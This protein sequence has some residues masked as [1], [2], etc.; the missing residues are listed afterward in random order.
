MRKGFAKYIFLG[1]VI[2]IML[3][4]LASPMSMSET[5]QSFDNQIETE[6][7]VDDFNLVQPHTLSTGE[8][9]LSGWHYRQQHTMLAGAGAG[10]NYA[11]TLHVEYGAGSS[12]GGIFHSNS[13]CQ[14]NFGDIRFTDNN[15]NTQLDYWMEEK[16]DSDDAT[17]WIEIKDSL[18][19][20]IS[21]YVYYGTTGTSSTTSS[22]TN[23]F[24]FFDDFENNNLNRW[25]TAGSDWSTSTS[26]VKYGT[27]AAYGD[28]DP[29]SENR[30]L[31]HDLTVGGY[32]STNIMIHLW[33]QVDAETYESHYGYATD[34]G[35]STAYPLRHDN[36][37]WVYDNGPKLPWESNTAHDDI[38]Y[39]IELV[40]DFTSKYFRLWID[41]NSKGSIDLEDATG[42]DISQFGLWQII[43][44]NVAGEDMW[45]DDVYIRKW[46]SSEPAHSTWLSE[47]NSAP[48]NDVTP[49]CTNLD[50]GDNLYARYR[51]YNFSVSVTDVCGA[52]NINYV[53]LSSMNG[54]TPVWTVK[55]LESDNSFSEI[56][57]TTLIELTGSV[58]TKSGVNL[59]IWFGVRIE[60]AHVD[61][62][63][64]DLKQYALDDDGLSDTDTYSAIDYDYDTDLTT[65]FTLNDGSGTADHGNYNSI[66]SITASGTV[67]YEDSGG[68]NYP[69]TAQVDMFIR[70]S[71]V[72][73][74]DWV[75]TTFSSGAWS[76]TVDSDNVIGLDTY[77]VKAVQAG[78]NYDSATL[79]GA[80]TSDTYIADRIR[81]V[82]YT[83]VSPSGDNRNNIGTTYTIDIELHYD[84]YETDVVDGTVT[85]NG[86]SMDS[87]QG[88][89]KWRWTP[90]QA[91]VTGI[92]YNNMQ[93]SGNAKGITVE[94]N[95]VTQLI[96]W[97]RIKVV[98]Y[99]IVSP[100]G[101]NRN[102]IGT[103]Y[104]ID[105]ELHYDYDE[106][107]VADGTI[108]VNGE[109]MD[110]YQ[111]SGKWR[112]T[113]TQA[114]VTGITYNNMQ[115]TGNTHGIT[116][117]DNTVTQ[118]IIWDRI[119]VMSYTIVN[120]SG[121]NR[122]NIGTTYTI[123]IELHYDYD[124]TDVADGTI[125][126]NGE[127]MDS[128]QGSGKWRWTPTQAGVIG[129]TYNNMQ[130]TG[131][132]H[133]I[134]SEDNTVTQ[135]II[136]DRVQVQ[137]YT[138][139]DDW[140][141]INDNVN[142]DFLVWY[143]YDN[144][145]VTDGDFTLNGYDAS[146]VGSGVWR[147]TRTSASPA[148][149]TYNTVL[150]SDTNTHGIDV[151]DQNGKS[152]QVVWD[153]VTIT[154]TGPTDNRQNL[155]AN[156]SGIHITITMD[157][158]ETAY[159]GTATMNNTD[160]NGDGT[161]VRWGYTISSVSGGTYGITTIS[162]NDDT[163]MIWDQVKV[164]GYST[165]STD[166]HDNINDGVLI[167]VWLQYDYD[168]TNVT[169]GTV[170]I[171][172][173]TYTYLSNGNFTAEFV[174]A[175]ASSA[176]WDT[177]VITGNTHGITSV[178]QNSKSQNFKWDSLTISLTDPADQRQNLNANA[179]GFHPTAAYDLGGAYD[180]TLGLNNTDYNGD[181]T[182]VRWG[183]E[184]D[185]ANG[186]D[187][188]GITAISDNSDTT[189]MIWDR[190]I[191]LTTTTDDGRIDINT[192]AAIG[193]TA[194]L[195]YDNHALG[196]GDTLYMNGTSMSWNGSHFTL[197]PNFAVVDIWN[198][199]VN[200]SSANEATY[201]ITLINLDSNNIN[202]IWDSLTVTITNPTDQRININANA[203]GMHVS[204]IWDYDSE[205]YDG[206]LTLN[207]TTYDHGTVGIY[208][209]TVTVGN[210][211][212]SYGITVVS[213]SDSV[214]CIFDRIKI[215]TTAATDN[216]I[217]YGTESTTVNVTAEL[218]YDSHGLGSGDT[219]YMNDTQMTWD[220]DHFYI[221]FGPYSVVGSWDLFVN[222]S[223][224]NEVT[225]GIT[226][227]WLNGQ[228]D[229]V[230]T[231]RVIVISYAISD[232][233]DNINDYIWINVTVQ[234]ESDNAVVTDGTI[235][236][237]SYSFTHLG[238][239]IW[240]HNRTQASA[241]GI[242][243][244][245]AVASGNTRGI[246]VVNQ[247]GQSQTA[248][249]DSYTVSFTVDDNRINIDVNATVGYTVIS[250]HDAIAYDGTVNLNY[251]TWEQST[252]QRQGF[253]VSSLSGDDTYGITVIS[254][255][256]ADY[257]IWDS[258][259][260]SFTVGDN[261]ININVN[262][263][264]GYTVISDYDSIAYDGTVNL[265]YT[266]WEQASV[267][268]QG[269]TVS[270]LAGD[271]TYGITAIKTNDADYLI[272]DAIGINMWIDDGR[273]NI[274][275][276]ITVYAWLTYMYDMTNVTD[277]TV[278]LNGTGMSYGSSIWSLGR[279]QAS[280]GLWVYNITSI[281]G[282]TYGITEIGLLDFDGSDYIDLGGDASLELTTTYTI[283]LWFKTG[284]SFTNWER[285][286]STYTG[287]AYRCIS[288]DF[289]AG[290]IL[291]FF[292]RGTDGQVNLYFTDKTYNDSVWHY[293][294]AVRNGTDFRIYW[295]GVLLDST[296]SEHDGDGL[297]DEWYLGADGSGPSSYFNGSIDMVRIYNRTLDDYEIYEHYQGRYVDD[298][299]L[300]LYLPLTTYDVAD[301]V[302]YDLSDEGNDGT[303]VGVTGELFAGSLYVRPIWD[304]YTV[305]FTVDDNRINID[306]NATV[307]YTVI[308]DYD[309]IAY[310]GTVNLNYTTYN[311]TTVQ[312][313]G[314]TV[315]SLDGDDTYG[316]TA[317]GT[318]DDDYVIWDEI[319]VYWSDTTDSR[320]NY[321]EVE[322]PVFK[323]RLKY[324]GGGTHYLTDGTNDEVNINGSA[325]TWVA[326]ALNYWY[327]NYNYASVS[328]YTFWVT[329]ALEHTYGIT[330]FDTASATAYMKWI[331][332]DRVIVLGYNTNSTDNRD[333]VNDC[334][335]VSVWIQYEYDSTNV[336]DGTI[337]INSD[338]YAYNAGSG[339]WT[340]LFSNATASDATWD[341]IVASG[342]TYGITYENQNGK[343]QKV[344][345]DSLTITMT[346]PSDNRIDINVNAS[347]IGMSAIRDYDSSGFDGTLT[348]NDTT[349]DHG[350]VGIY[351][352]TIQS[353]SGGT[354]DITVIST[355]DDTYCIF[356]RILILTTAATDGR[357]NYGLDNT[358]LNVTARLEYTGGGTHNLGSG[359]TLYMNDTSM[360][361]NTDHFYLVTDIYSIAD[362]INYFVNSSSANEATYGITV[363]YLDGNSANVIWD[364]VQV[365]SYT[366]TDSWVDVNANVNI[367]VLLYYDY[368][369]TDVT[370]GTVTLNGNAMA[371]QGSGTWRY[372][373]NEASPTANT[374]DTIATSGNTHGLTVV[375]QQSL[376]HEVIW[377]RIIWQSIA[378][379]NTTQDYGSDGYRVNEGIYVRITLQLQYEYNSTNLV[380]GTV[381]LNGESMTYNTTPGYWY[382][383]VM[384]STSAYGQHYNFT[385][386]VVSGNAQGI[387]VE[388]QNSQSLSVIWDE[389]VVLTTA[390][391]D[392]YIDPTESTTIN[393]TAQL[394]Y[395][396]HTVGSGDTL[397]MNDTSMTWDT[398][399][400]Y[401]TV[402]PYGGVYV[403]EF[404]VNSTNNNEATYAITAIDVDG[405]S[406]TI[407]SEQV[408]VISYAISDARDNINDYIWVNVT[409]QYESDSASVVDGTIVI[410][411]Y[412]FT[413][414]GSGIWRHNRT[415]STVVGRTFD[416]VVASGNA[417]SI[418]TV[419][420]N[421]QSQVAIWDRIIILTTVATD[422][423]IDY[424]TTTMI[425]VTAQ[426]EYTTGGVHTIGSGDT[427]YMNDTSMTWDI[428]HWYITT[429]A[430]NIVDIINYFVNSSSANEVTYGI[431]VVNLDGN[432]DD[433]IWDRILILT[434]VVTDGRIDYG[435]TTTLNVTA[436]LEYDSHALG[437]GDTLYMNGTSMTWDTNHF[438]LTT[439]AY[440]IVDIINY[441][442][443]SS[444]A[445]EATYTI[446]VVNVD[447]NSDDVIWDRIKILTT[448]TDDNR[449]SYDTQ[450][451]IVVTAQLEYDYHVLGS[452]D[453]LYMNGTQMTWNGSHFVLNPQFT[454][455]DIWNFYVN[456]TSASE[457]TYGITVIYLDGNSVNQIWDR[458]AFTWNA[459]MTW[460]IVNYY[461][462]I[463]FTAT[464]EYD[465]ATFAGNLTAANCTITN[466]TTSFEV[467]TESPYENYTYYTTSVIDDV[468]G[469]TSYINTVT[470]WCVF[471]NIT[472]TESHGVTVTDYSKTF[473]I[474]F[475]E[476]Q[477]QYNGSNIGIDWLCLNMRN[478]TQTTTAVT[479]ADSVLSPIKQE[480]YV[481]VTWDGVLYT[482][483]ATKTIG[484]RSYNFQWYSI[485]HS[486]MASQTI[487]VEGI[488]IL[489]ITL[490][491]SG[492]TNV[493][494]TWYIYDDDSPTGETD[495]VVSANDFKIEFDK[496]IIYG[497]CNYSIYFDAGGSG[498]RWYNSSY[499]NDFDLNIEIPEQVGD[500]MEVKGTS[501]VN[502]EWHIYNRDT[503]AWTGEYDSI[504][505]GNN[506]FQFLFTLQTASGKHNYSLYF[507]ISV[508]I[509]IWK[510]GTY[511][512]APTI[513]A[514]SSPV[515]TATEE[516]NLLSGTTNVACDWHVYNNDTE[517]DTG[518]LGIGS[519]AIS[520]NKNTTTGYYIWG[521]KFD[522][523]TT[524]RWV[525]GTFEIDA[526]ILD[527]DI[528]DWGVEGVVIEV[529]GISNLDISWYIYNEDVYSTESGSETAD[530]GF[531]FTFAKNNSVGK[532]NFSIYFNDT[533][534]GSQSRWFNR[535]YTISAVYGYS[536]ISL[537]NSEGTG[538]DIN[539]F[540][541]YVNGTQYYGNE[542]YDRTDCKYNITVTDYFGYTIHSAIH[543]YDQ[544]INVGI[545]FYI[546]KVQSELQ[547]Q[548]V[549]F[550][551][552]RTGGARFSQHLLA[553]EILTYYLVA[554]E[555]TYEFKKVAS[556]VMS[557]TFIYY[558]GIFTLSCDK[559]HIIDGTNLR[560]IV[561]D[562]E[563]IP[564]G[565]ANVK[566]LE[567]S[568]TGLLSMV[569]MMQ[570]GMWGLAFLL[571]MGMAATATDEEI[572]KDG[573][574]IKKRKIPKQLK[575]FAFKR[576]AKNPKSKAIP[577]EAGRKSWKGIA[578]RDDVEDWRK[579]M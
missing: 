111:G 89:G 240:R 135:L 531:Q 231:D 124:E 487:V 286:I 367:D 346:G 107:D 501:N 248:V 155:N 494:F 247:N 75:D 51:V 53:E 176:T 550:N 293:I 208:Y 541:V 211:D 402:G 327:K 165:N 126:V 384:N 225:Y 199:F 514:I 11:I 577:K 350:S 548:E 324:D 405:N 253:T 469:I 214:Y 189:Y 206:T 318:N 449:V 243:F 557:P 579:K 356:D 351:Y 179:T 567:E 519:F 97:D 297:R 556:N 310:D 259:T 283:S 413:H 339:N 15:G 141:N 269:F 295:D 192:A 299:G 99:T 448:V 220:T 3:C 480:I 525:N 373:T 218:E 156:A 136:W 302:W 140:V 138:I 260:I 64:Y 481:P 152:R 341:T 363:I 527:V 376:S 375:D 128:Y 18:E 549:Y 331:V 168:D 403:L 566:P 467:L 477:W 398:D 149:V 19:L 515:Y 315:S 151:E 404:F 411:G 6:E 113:P 412:S 443:N 379:V 429:G 558:Q 127:S 87:Y 364:R 262:A 466:S 98:S 279:S 32:E 441:F 504:T 344:I 416:T 503:S 60:W 268:R 289:T 298:T 418:T 67:S 172:S 358:T 516:H 485:V 554:G 37:D 237:N 132:T 534:D 451:T 357:I 421:G 39:R 229:T 317:I 173:E 190:I 68:N 109:S 430:Y 564:T 264:V 316:I 148:L 16:T 397:R 371:H 461:I 224:A 472:A 311:Q 197:A 523:G 572:T 452:G 300:V 23:T 456:S 175:T 304:S 546:Y 329:S 386:I 83:I 221:V 188:Y 427:L 198:F 277:G 511:N 146:H 459:N 62:N 92:T 522:D 434:T 183:Y 555:Y 570:L 254:T 406:A 120:P 368:D 492:I 131:N 144:T 207:D 255:N 66:D 40:M 559:T 484:G 389:I 319:E 500:S 232:A 46:V 462:N 540:I 508:S 56:L 428:D 270:S 115:A 347:G 369:N 408:K 535:S 495:S 409:V 43:C 395:D 486:V 108:T 182:V 345:W 414:L 150:V 244:D 14:T 263:T 544:H 496:S 374:Y 212:G 460:T 203:S 542:F 308:S 137:S 468:Y 471:D 145:Q 365:Q 545:V 90:T 340:A 10:T 17:F 170:T 191:I 80:T 439:G 278:L 174:N 31:K 29:V 88:S 479:L 561:D 122:N 498:D 322:K 274:D 48:I 575:R 125:T 204:A 349:Y 61:A 354:Y 79:L 325:A 59:D 505:G 84:L 185:T 537:Y 44:S 157:Y 410:N 245:T 41:R 576:G 287:G 153:S 342:N 161:V 296:E 509:Y 250:D 81:V 571:I 313:Q 563:L 578:F 338:S 526:A 171:N 385:T 442:V 25:T 475:G 497:W 117:E 361:W 82:S 112:W 42:A 169:D 470:A 553:G 464:H 123:D 562:I 194:K 445:N 91:G 130:A 392:N 77:Y 7:N 45:V 2:F 491:V 164:L 518:T 1:I 453:T 239:G 490:V 463:S 530:I 474:F 147:I 450:A 284:A 57:G 473:F 552:T 478:G 438:Y 407:G 396:N 143:D 292:D 343:S 30:R 133:G 21:F 94:D 393:V 512:I 226:A 178:N 424:G 36:N 258:Y 507:N 529:V 528:E 26:R 524:V 362:I 336:T 242:T 235:V 73:G 76:M 265:N 38:W 275:D 425:N 320:T 285:I 100:S 22:G 74:S 110:S 306:T 63:D 359:D 35:A 568:M 436:E 291:E 510:N 93:I 267:Q 360:T 489:D 465:S 129:I 569:S 517:M 33:G 160:Y 102:N 162:S 415:E 118:L 312:R 186:D 215:L 383:D 50:D 309:S 328:N 307:G 105:I 273:D 506:Y 116:V 266:T 58:Y 538:L 219:L 104:T 394:R 69:T 261:R 388:N 382:L 560:D 34:T 49:A 281:S 431:D 142:I 121:D 372:T 532:H 223:S 238:S 272:W 337:V 228:S 251:T 539:C 86:E 200:S 543:D 323:L 71:D 520:W 24:L 139:T 440:N 234:Y 378:H 387:T 256:D 547:G 536:Q 565:K 195:E 399:H 483:N 488:R 455:V 377:D 5:G 4:L 196:S 213:S 333:N 335:N 352:Y 401:L 20:A 106:T 432:N 210:G 158:N 233:R 28:A 13:K 52:T 437:T 159:G 54:A 276:T 282:N 551:L 134:T 227:V 216:Y 181:G 391:T 95:T 444:S 222:S 85:V 457:A 230:A 180:G 72:A 288:L 334:F 574:V 280:A 521:A 326:D 476:L 419:N 330:A 420:Q 400:W 353:A 417:R 332:W 184:V 458:V 193:A 355:N 167:N 246:T 103:T 502:C 321:N 163:Y 435:T 201:G 65:T 236:I 433:V 119:K 422:G 252:A 290:G 454:D 447:G 533:V 390:A 78:G 370:D 380:D 177:V 257:V 271:D 482:N 55:Y 294:V 209:Y 70:C 423:R 154:I 348:L 305:A 241:T 114:G 314:Y 96:I 381:T 202:Q 573:K 101:D 426:L 446:T 12:S 366:V 8:N 9:W 27:Y 47:E 166:N 499:F 187:T 205:A 513:L 217:E 493:D 249:W 303:I 301:G